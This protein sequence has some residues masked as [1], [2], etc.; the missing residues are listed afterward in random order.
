MFVTSISFRGTFESFWDRTEVSEQSWCKVL[1]YEL[2]NPT[3]EISLFKLC[4]KT[5]VVSRIYMVYTWNEDHSNSKGVHK[6]MQH[7]H[8]EMQF[9]ESILKM[10]GIHCPHV[11]H[12]SVLYLNGSLLYT[13]KRS[14]WILYYRCM[15]FIVPMSYMGL[16][17]I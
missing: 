2:V 4:I 10:H 14:F 13:N 7:V 8:K 11:V 9:L 6:Q 17:Y 16:C 12:G 1:T 5:N 3:F 15:R